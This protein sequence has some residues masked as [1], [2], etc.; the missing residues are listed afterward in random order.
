MPRYVTVACMDAGR[1]R[2]TD[3]CQL[4]AEPM[5]KS[6]STANV[7]AVTIGEARK[8]SARVNGLSGEF[9]TLRLFES[10]AC[11]DIW[12]AIARYTEVSRYRPYAARKTI[13]EDRDGR[14]ATARRG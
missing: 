1:S 14:Q 5:R 12:S 2:C 3:A 11:C 6:G 7:V 4:C 13:D 9:W 8:P 10:G